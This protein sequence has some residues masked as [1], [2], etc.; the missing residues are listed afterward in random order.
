M[1]EVRVSS[2]FLSRSH[3]DFI[4]SN[5]AREYQ[6]RCEFDSSDYS[7]PFLVKSRQH[8]AK[9]S[10][11]TFLVPRPRDLD[12]L[13]AAVALSVG[14][15]YFD[16]PTSSIA[17][18]SKSCCFTCKV[19]TVLKCCIKCRGAV[20]YCSK[21]CQKQDWKQHKQICQF[22]NVGDGAVQVRSDVHVDRYTTSEEKFEMVRRSFNE[23]DKRFFKLFTESTREGSR[24]AAR[25]MQKIA[26][27]QTPSNQKMLLLY[28]LFLL[29][30]TDPKKLRWPN[31]PLRIMFQS[32]D[33]NLCLAIAEEE[34]SPEEAAPPI[35]LSGRP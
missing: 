7:N 15:H 32:V 1:F 26:A 13:Y 27:R 30:H 20:Q 25:E 34:D 10:D 6:Y 9:L 18:M 14:T 31:S 11:G 5:T 19:H 2:M 35:D 24:A 28:S 23:D 3:L 16:P 17:I 22:L 33:A 8:A 4:I 29:M 21:S 12:L